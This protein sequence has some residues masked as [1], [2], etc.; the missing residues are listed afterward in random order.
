MTSDIPTLK[1][2]A[3][4]G[5]VAG[6]NSHSKDEFSLELTN[7]GDRAWWATDI[8]GNMKMIEPENT[9]TLALGTK[10]EFGEIDGEIVQ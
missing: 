5:V 9:L 3:S 7:L 6:I 4:N 10:I 1:A 2:T 8:Q